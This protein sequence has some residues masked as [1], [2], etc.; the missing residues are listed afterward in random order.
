MISDPS[1]R[2]ITHVSSQIVSLSYSRLQ[3]FVS[4]QSTYFGV[5]KTMAQPPFSQPTRGSTSHCP[6]R[7]SCGRNNRRCHLNEP[8]GRDYYQVVVPSPAVSKRQYWFLTIEPGS[9]VHAAACLHPPNVDD[10]WTHHNLYG[11]AMGSVRP[12]SA[13]R[14]VSS[15]ILTLNVSDVDKY[16]SFSLIPPTSNS[17]F[18]TPHWRKDAFKL[19][20]TCSIS[21]P[22]VAIVNL[23]Y[24]SKLATYPLHLNVWRPRKPDQCPRQ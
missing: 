8:F 4:R 2:H 15:V 23:V 24:D 7:S 16:P 9:V 12:F 3:P 17:A 18:S 11:R 10:V 21:T 22:L 13:L 19:R 6:R 14:S 5:P 20:G 1:L